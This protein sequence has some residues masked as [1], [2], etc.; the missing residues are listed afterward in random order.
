MSV[1]TQRQHRM[2]LLLADT[3]VGSQA[4]LRDLMA[5]EGYPLS[6]VT[7]SRD[8]EELGAVK[9][10]SGGE[11]L[12]AV[13]EIATQRSVPPDV[14]RR[15]CSEWVVGVGCSGNLVVLSTPPGSAHVVAS[16]VD[17]TTVAGVLGTVAGD[18]TI[19]VVV[20]EAVGGQAVATAFAEMAGL[21]G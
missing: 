4:Q 16:A 19:L 11:L 17:R 13:P 10:R 15:V 9:L 7:V 1:K 6:Q 14:L 20:D 2:A 5:A 18:D 12:Y 3:A 8:L 21:P